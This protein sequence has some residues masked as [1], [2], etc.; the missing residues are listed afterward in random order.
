MFETIAIL[1]EG[2]EVQQLTAADRLV[3]ATTE[4]T[5]RMAILANVHGM[6]RRLMSSTCA[7]EAHAYAAH[8]AMNHADVTAYTRSS[9]TAPWTVVS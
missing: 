4:R 6:R 7:D 1:A 2:V 8:F 5:A 3:L 9:A